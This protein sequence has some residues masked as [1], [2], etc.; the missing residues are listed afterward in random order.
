[1]LY[2]TAAHGFKS[3]GF[4]T[5]FGRL[6]I[7]G[8][9]FGDE[10]IMSYEAGIKTELW[11]GRMRLAASVFYTE[12]DDYQ[13]AAFVGAQFTVGNAAKA[14]LKG[15]DFEGTVLLTESLTA[16]FA[17]SY[18]DFTYDENTSGQCY[19]GRAPNSPTDP[20]ACDLSGENPVNAPEWKTHVGVLYEHPVSWGDVYARADW[21]WTSEYNTSFSADP[22]LVQDAYSW[23]NVRV[24]TRWDAYELVAWVD[25]A[26][27]EEVVNF[28]AVVN[29]YAGDGSTQSFL[30]APRSYGL[31]FRVNY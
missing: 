14:E 15:V 1:M 25:N 3:G 11:E 21:S 19:P 8:R 2:A 17:V 20:S 6:P 13:D 12:Y 26:T 27:D 30:Q 10:D 23:V 22:R 28:D 29:I 18:A 16:D 5:G 24:G 7:D 4:N 9:E 31:T